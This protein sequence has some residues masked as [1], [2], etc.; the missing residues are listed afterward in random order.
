MGIKKGE[1]VAIHL[2]NCPQ[3]A[4]AYYGALKK[5]RGQSLNSE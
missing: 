4:I 3:F 5:N 2:P 1:K